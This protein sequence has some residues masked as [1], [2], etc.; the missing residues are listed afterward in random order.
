MDKIFSLLSEKIAVMSFP[1]ALGQ[2]GGGG[3]ADPSC[4]F[5]KYVNL[6]RKWKIGLHKG[7]FS[8]SPPLK[9]CNGPGKYLVRL[10]NWKGNNRPIH[11]ICYRQKGY[12]RRFRAATAKWYRPNGIAQNVPAKWILGWTQIEYIISKK[13]CSDYY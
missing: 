12:F 3:L 1:P 9:T 4:S 11:Y 8:T 7:P 2:G 10:Y 13:I 5:L 6:K